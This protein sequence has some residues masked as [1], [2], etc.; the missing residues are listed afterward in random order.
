MN[1][2]NQLAVS[3]SLLGKL[4]SLNVDKYRHASARERGIQFTDRCKEHNDC[5]Q[6]GNTIENWLNL[7]VKLLV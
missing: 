7:Y 5:L 1:P 6:K 3:W 4:I 2:N